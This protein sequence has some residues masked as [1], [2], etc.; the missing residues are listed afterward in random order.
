MLGAEKWKSLETISICLK[1]WL[2]ACSS[3]SPPFPILLLPKTLVS[4]ARFQILSSFSNRLTWHGSMLVHG[5]FSS[6]PIGSSVSLRERLSICTHTAC[7][8]V[9]MQLVTKRPTCTCTNLLLPT[10]ITDNLTP[11]STWTMKKVRNRDD[12]LVSWCRAQSAV[13]CPPSSL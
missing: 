7:C 8:S 9:V 10:P 5:I 1:Y 6:A 4:C 12:T 2:L 13:Y 3:L 11:S